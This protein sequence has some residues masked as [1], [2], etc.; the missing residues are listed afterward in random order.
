MGKKYKPR[1]LLFL[2]FQSRLPFPDVLDGP[3]HFRA[4]RPQSS[5]WFYSFTVIFSSDCLLVTKPEH[6]HCE[7][8]P[9][10]LKSPKLVLYICL[11][12]I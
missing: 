2:P 9:Q 4:R 10:H 3:L 6:M 5:S 12:H 1:R 7:E 8:H 11:L